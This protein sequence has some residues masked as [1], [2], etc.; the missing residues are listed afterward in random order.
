MARGDSDIKRTGVSWTILQRIPKRYQE[1]VLCGR[2]LSFFSSL[3]ATN[4]DM[5]FSSV[6]FFWLNMLKSTA[7][8]FAVDLLSLNT[9]RNTKTAFLTHKRYDEHSRHFYMGGP[10]GKDGSQQETMI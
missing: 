4:S 2:G 9:L 1:L 5:I 6:I 10:P 7:E 8:A 3:R